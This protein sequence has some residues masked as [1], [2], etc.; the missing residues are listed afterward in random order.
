MKRK[1]PTSSSR[2]SVTLADT[3][4]RRRAPGGGPLA[5]LANLRLF[6]KRGLQA[7]LGHL[8]TMA[9]ELRDQLEGHAATT[10]MNGN[11]F[12]PVTLFRVYPDGVDTFS[13]PAQERTDPSCRET[14]LKHNEYN[15]RIYELIQ[16]DALQGHGVVIDNPV[17]LQGIG[18]DRWKMGEGAVVVLQQRL[19]A[20]R[21]GALLRGHAERL[22]SVRINTEQ[23]D[24]SRSCCRSSRSSPRV[25]SS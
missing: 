20:G 22:D 6:G 5:A 4:S 15:R 17:S 10:V 12:G 23:R 11:N 25:T 8:V 1:R 24:P 14:L 19:A 13:M 21:V 9:E 2:A 18:L 7:L 16:A 3:R